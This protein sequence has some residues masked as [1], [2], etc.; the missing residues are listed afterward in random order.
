MVSRVLPFQP[1]VISWVLLC[2]PPIVISLMTAEAGRGQG[3]LS[4]QWKRNGLASERFTINGTGSRNNPLRRSLKTPFDGSEFFVRFKLRYH[5]N[6]L[7]SPPETSGEFFVLWLDQDEG[8]DGS[9]HAANIPNLGVHVQGDQNRFMIR[10]NSSN[11]KFGESIEGDRDYAIVGRLWKSS[12]EKQQPFDQL[13]LW[14]DPKGSEE[15][16]PDVSVQSQQSISKIQWIGFSTG[17]KT[18]IED[19]IDVW[20]I[21]VAKSWRE[22]LNLP[23]EPADPNYAPDMPQPPT[24]KTIS[25]RKHIYPILKKHCYD[26]HSGE[27]AEDG[28]RLDTQ[29]EVLQHISPLLHSESQLYQVLTTGR[30]PPEGPTLSG[31]EIQL[32]ADWIDEGLDWDAE[33]LPTPIPV[34]NHWAFQPITRPEIP[35][36]PSK[37]VCN[38]ID[39]FIAAKHQQVGL[40]PNASA[41]PKT[42]RRRLSLD[43][44]GLPPRPETS[45]ETSEVEVRSMLSAPAYGQHFARRWLDIARWAESNGHQHNRARKHAWRYRDWVIDAFSEGMS[46]DDFVHQ[47]VAGDELAPYRPAQLIAT[48]FLAAAR[49]SGNELDK[50]IQ[51]NDILVDITNTTASAFMGVT[52]GQVVREVFT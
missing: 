30:M 8:N 28:I 37:W 20:D 2:I 5:A 51:R 41:P 19:Q 32:M 50:Q 11:Q 46:F 10:Y 3:L 34:S 7:D 9:P 22:I 14:I 33:L 29:D 6:S 48:G 18:E 13:S 44:H 35:A 49:Y 39:S 25:F 4:N 27:D 31:G 43:L 42:L 17:A 21:R 45:A 16:K 36:V 24:K 38:P 12:P 1:K 52:G 26:C 15:L 47:Q 40:T 23:A